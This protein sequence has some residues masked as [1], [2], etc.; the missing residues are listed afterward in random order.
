MSDLPPECALKRTRH[1]FTLVGARLPDSRSALAS[2]STP[3]VGHST[4]SA[5]HERSQRQTQSCAEKP[6][7]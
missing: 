7:P 6:R 2:A 5:A 1:G 3:T 4:G